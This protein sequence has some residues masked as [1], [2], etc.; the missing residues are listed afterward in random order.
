ML[1]QL[2]CGQDKT[3]VT[4]RNLPDLKGR[5]GS[6]E[7]VFVKVFAETGDKLAAAKA[8]GYSQPRTAASK[9]LS[10]PGVQAEIAKRQQEILFSEILPL[11]VQVHKQILA[12]DRTPAGARVQAVKL[13]YDRTFGAQEGAQAKEP[14]EMT[15]D[16]LAKMIEQLER[17]ASNR[18]KPVINHDPVN[19]EPDGGVFE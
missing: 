18:A 7:T 11:A 12:D 15:A 16:E 5:L 14:H 2:S 6:Q 19:P 9:A 8:A 4:E 17:E 13:A 3:K 1:P 10:R